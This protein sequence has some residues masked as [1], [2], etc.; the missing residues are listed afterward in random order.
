MDTLFKQVSRL[1]SVRITCKNSER[2]KLISFN[3]VCLKL[4]SH[5]THLDTEIT[6][7]EDALLILKRLEHLSHVEFRSKRNILSRRYEICRLLTDMN[8][9][10]ILET[11]S[12]VTG[13]YDSDH[14]YDTASVST[15]Q[16]EFDSCFNYEYSCDLR[17]WR[18]KCIHQQL[19]LPFS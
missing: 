17:I 5:V 10:F 11:H 14:D 1:R 13:D 7:V 2:M 6:H 3:A 8:R 4:P 15:S 9:E 16:I 12:S 18:S 19:N